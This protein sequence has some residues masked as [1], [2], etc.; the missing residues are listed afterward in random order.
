MRLLGK[1]SFSI[2]LWHWPILII[3]SED[4]P[5]PLSLRDRLS[6]VAASLGA[7]AVTY[8]TLENPIRNSKVLARK[9]VLSIGV[10]LFVVIAILSISTYKLHTN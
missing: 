10:G 9:T 3:A 6:L 4:A 2:Y 8:Y 1:L 7:A 5:H